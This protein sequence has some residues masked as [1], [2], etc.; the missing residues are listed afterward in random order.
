MQTYEYKH[1]R[2]VF[3][4]KA[5]AW[6]RQHAVQMKQSE[7]PVAA[8]APTSGAGAENPKQKQQQQQNL[9]VI[10]DEHPIRPITSTVDKA[11]DPTELP[12]DINKENPIAS[13]GVGGGVKMQ[14]EKLKQPSVDTGTA[15][16]ILDGSG[17]PQKKSKL[18]LHRN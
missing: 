6:T 9:A 12:V 15:G 7:A 2:E 13:S 11:A 17:P 18:S 3:D 16:K 10:E 14:L 4:S 5:R 1:Q 8:T